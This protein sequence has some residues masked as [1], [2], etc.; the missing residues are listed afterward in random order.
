[1]ASTGVIFS[2]GEFTDSENG[3]FI[4]DLSIKTGH[5]TIFYIAMLVDQM[6]TIPKVT[7]IDTRSAFVYSLKPPKL[8]GS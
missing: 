5:F 8:S 1:M 4:D 6:V 2:F 7:Q 3:P